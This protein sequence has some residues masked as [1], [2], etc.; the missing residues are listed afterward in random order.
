VSQ[1]E[2]NPELPETE[3][4]FIS[5]LLEMRDRM[6][7]VVIAL[8]LIF[9]VLFP[10]AN[11]IYHFLATP[12]LAH[13]PAGSSMIAVEVIS[14]FL[15]PLKMALYAALLVGMPYLLFQAWSFV[16][17]GLYQ[18]EK[19][20][21]MPLLISSIVLFY[22]GVAFAYFIV[23]PLVFSFLISVAPE[24]VAVMTDINKYLDFVLALFFAFGLAFEIPIATIILIAMGV[25]DADSLVAKRP[26][27]IVGAFVIGMFLTPPDVISQIM[28]AL[29]MWLLFEGGIIMSRV[30][31]QPRDEDE[32]TEDG[33]EFNVGAG[34][35]APAAAAAA[36]GAS[37]AGADA[38]EKPTGYSA[39]AYPDDYKP[40]TWEEMEAEIDEA[41]KWEDEDEDEDSEDS[42]DSD[43]EDN[44]DEPKSESDVHDETI[45]DDSEESEPDENVDEKY[46][47]RDDDIGP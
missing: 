8:T 9:A 12:L 5:H 38:T 42:E 35:A 22:A 44:D 1:T 39:S 26:Y 17:P 6:I 23:F 46:E 14:P 20:L 31:I 28:L 18:H 36:A 47:K 43:K 41:S 7:R 25:T 19:R 29:P 37:A 27:I 21:A 16:A 30:L 34:K 32:E 24:G 15:T 4:G 13:M 33:T 45:A 40:L 10:F 3:T 11:E 2:Q